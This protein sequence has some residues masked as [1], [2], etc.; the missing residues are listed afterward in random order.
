MPACVKIRVSLHIALAIAMSGLAGCAGLRCPRIDPS[1]ERLFVCSRD[2]VTPVAA[3]ANPVAP[4]VYTDPVF[5]QPALPGAG[6]QVGGVVPPVPQDRLRITPQ[7]VL[8]PVGSEVILRAGLCTRENYLLTDSKIEWL[9]ARD[10]VGEFVE[11]GG[12][13]WCKDPWLPW[14]KPKKIDNQYAIG[15]SAKVPLSITRGTA[16]TTDDVEVQPGEAWASVTSPVEGVS[17]VTAVAPEI[18][19]WA[20]RRAVATIYWVDV[21]WTFPP[22]TVTAGGGQVLTTTVLRQTDGTPLEGW[23]VRYQVADGDGSLRGGQEGQVVEVRTDAQG[24]A[25]IDVTPTGSAGSTTRI[26][27]QLVRPAGFGGSSAPKLDIASG[28]TLI[29]WTDGDYVPQ[30][31]DLGD[32][33]PPTNFPPGG[34]TAPIQPPPTSNVMPPVVPDRARIGPRLEVE[35]AQFGNAIPQVGDSVRFEYVLKNTGDATATGII[36]RD[37]FDLGLTNILDTVGENTIR[38]D[39]GM[40]PDIAA[41]TSYSLNQTFGVQKSGQLCQNVTVTYNGANPVTVTKCIDVP[42]PQVQRQGRLEVTKD[43]PPV[44][45]V[46][47]TVTFTL[48]VRNIG[49]APLRNIEVRDSYDP[50]LQA[51]QFGNAEFFNG[52][53][54]WLIPQIAPN[55]T[56]EQK[57][58]CLCRAPKSNVCG[59][60]LVTA[61]TGPVPALSSSATHCLNIQPALPNVTPDVVPGQGDNTQ[62]LGVPPADRAATQNNPGGLSMEILLFGNPVTVDTRTGFQ[63]TLKNNATIVDEQVRL[64]VQFPPGLQPDVEAFQ[65]DNNLQAQFNN[66]ELQIEPI[67]TLRNGEKLGIRISCNVLQP[68]VRDIVARVQSN[69]MPQ[70]IQVSKQIEILAG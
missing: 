66:G 20:N 19:E 15:Y 39:P 13:G 25:S 45:T 47:Q 29:N 27:A 52:N 4:P 68:G 44:A 53:L 63:I 26:N 51:Q 50:E 42:Q 2:Q 67:R 33:V 36:L 69:N 12:R 59:T 54:R 57:V 34:S 43:G 32:V 40:I 58:T 48:R 5:P 56:W 11:L 23:V 6:P 30:P 31:D 35:V 70:P 7:R 41:G 10:E 17:R 28:N 46:D 55:A 49:D 21:Q 14:N 62:P 38:T 60:V 9:L 64:S 3:S 16:N 8:A 22:S 61:D 37:E 18:V 24:R 1:G 65:R